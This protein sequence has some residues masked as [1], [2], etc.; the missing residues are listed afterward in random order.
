MSRQKAKTIRKE[1]V[2]CLNVRDIA[3]GARKFRSDRT[4]QEALLRHH[5]KHSA[6]SFSPLLCQF[7]LA[8]NE[9]QVALGLGK[10]VSRRRVFSHNYDLFNSQ[11]LAFPEDPQARN[12]SCDDS[13]ITRHQPQGK[14]DSAASSATN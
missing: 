5:S 4:F 12:G 1:A 13:E 8:L 14:R 3:A 10:Q 11:E 6:N 7:N 9:L 2:M